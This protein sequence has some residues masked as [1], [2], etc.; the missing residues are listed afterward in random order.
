MARRSPSPE[1][2]QRDAERTRQKILEAARTEFSTNGY[3]GTRVAA[4]AD[5]AGVNKQLISYYFGGKE[6]LY[7]ELGRQ[8]YAYEDANIQT[9]DDPV[10]LI[11]RY[12]RTSIDQPDGSRL[13][14]WEGL[15]DTGGDDDDAPM[16]QARNARLRANNEPFRRAQ[17][18]GRLDARIDPDIFGLIMLGAATV[19]SVY[20]QLVRGVCHA[21]PRSPE[22][23]E[24]FADQLA[25]V[26][27][28]LLTPN[29]AGNDATQP[30]TPGASPEEQSNRPVP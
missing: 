7:A 16:T 15:A 17:A 8:W 14:A 6:G 26:M 19:P 2:R 24:R 4:I 25:T 28:L 30:S 3:A 11:R 13:L 23:I 1:D 20:P 29:Q 18:D 10:E 12:A 21:D 5:R 27:E 22:F 9:T